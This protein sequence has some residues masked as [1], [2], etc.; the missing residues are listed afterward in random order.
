[1]LRISSRWKTDGPRL[2]LEFARVSLN[3]RLTLVLHEGNPP[4]QMYGP[5][6]IRRSAQGGTR[7]I[8]PALGQEFPY[9]SL[10]FHA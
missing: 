9:C 2:P 4:Q 10:T 7:T 3:G 6:L 1:M 8:A 5:R